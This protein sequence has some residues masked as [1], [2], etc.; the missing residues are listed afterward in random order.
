MSIEAMKQALEALEFHVL[1]FD[2]VRKMELAIEALEKAIEQA[3]KQEP[4]AYVE[5]GDL[6]WCDD[7]STYDA[8]KLEG[9]TLYTA[10]PKHEWVGL[11]DVE[12]A[13]YG[14]MF[15]GVRLVKGIEALLKERNT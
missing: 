2:Q 12:I 3:E 7:V 15:S 6:Y 11:T 10:P 9:L 1:G 13:A 8:D 14:D 4:V 5:K